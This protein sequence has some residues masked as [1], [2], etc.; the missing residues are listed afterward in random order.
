VATCYQC[1]RQL[2]SPRYG[3]LGQPMCASCETKQTGLIVGATSGG[4]GG[5]VTGPRLLGWIRRSLGRDR[6]QSVRETDE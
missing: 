2:K 6:S 5:A 3:I 4:A 1:G